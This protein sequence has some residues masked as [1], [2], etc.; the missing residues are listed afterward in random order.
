MTDTTPDTVPAYFEVFDL[1]PVFTWRCNLCG[2]NVNDAPCLEHAPTEVPGLI[3]ARCEK[4]PRHN[5]FIYANEGAEA[6]GTGCT[7][8]DN[9]ALADTALRL[10][11]ATHRLWRRSRLTR[12]VLGLAY[13]LCLI[14][15]W[16]T[17]YNLYCAGCISVLYF[18]NPLATWRERR[19]SRFYERFARG[20]EG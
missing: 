19:L 4:D 20:L 17:D 5:V 11:H 1:D 15:G 9:I 14:S 18:R 8:C 7:A 3:L 10:R 12:R 2:R 13:R 16:G 6:Y